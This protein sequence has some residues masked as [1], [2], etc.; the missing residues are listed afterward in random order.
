M[1]ATNKDTLDII[2]EN[3]LKCLWSKNSLAFV[4]AIEL[5]NMS[6]FMFIALVNTISTSWIHLYQITCHQTRIFRISQYLYCSWAY[7]TIHKFLNKM[8]KGFVDSFGS[9]CI[10][11][12]FTSVTRLHQWYDVTVTLVRPSSDIQ[13]FSDFENL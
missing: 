9:W 3:I 11:A 10:T 12:S 1:D 4:L 7:N 13:I 8:L 5:S 6:D 2:D